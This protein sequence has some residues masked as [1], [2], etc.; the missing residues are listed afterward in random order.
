MPLE[1][2]ALYLASFQVYKED[3][4]KAMSEAKKKGK[5]GRK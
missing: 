5:K 2:K 4:E 3:N 1:E